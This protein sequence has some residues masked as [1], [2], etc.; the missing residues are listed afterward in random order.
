MGIHP[1]LIPRSL[2]PTGFPASRPK[3]TW[4]LPALCPQPQSV[5]SLELSPDPQPVLGLP[6]QAQAGLSSL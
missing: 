2:N 5:P 6:G 4:L 3:G 1:P